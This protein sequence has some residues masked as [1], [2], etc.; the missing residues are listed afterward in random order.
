M[1]FRIYKTELLTRETAQPT[2]SGSFTSSTGGGVWAATNTGMTF[3]ASETNDGIVFQFGDAFLA[4]SVGSPSTLSLVLQIS[5]NSVEQMSNLGYLPLS[6]SSTSL[7][8]CRTGTAVGESA[9]FSISSTGLV[10][11]NPTTNFTGSQTV[12]VENNA[13]CIY[14]V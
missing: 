7:I 8:P 2:M 1:A 11:I 9:V 6:G 14:T 5:T 12:G 4:T 10:T 3:T 13:V